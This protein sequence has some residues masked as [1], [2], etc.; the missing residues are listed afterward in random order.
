MA[1]EVISGTF[2]TAVSP[3]PTM[4]HVALGLLITF[5]G[6]TIRQARTY[7]KQK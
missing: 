5:Y 2:P 4:A 1:R 6:V 3:I 7:D